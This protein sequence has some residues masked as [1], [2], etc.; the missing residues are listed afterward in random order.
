M[1]PLL[2][3]RRMNSFDQ[4]VVEG[5]HPVDREK[6][7]RWAETGAALH[8]L[9]GLPARSRAHRFRRAA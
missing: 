2:G 9:L 4:R 3:C 7:R 8:E 1:L 6:L 5:F